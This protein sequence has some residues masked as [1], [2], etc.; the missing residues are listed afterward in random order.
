MAP[1]KLDIP[2]AIARAVM[3]D[4]R[5]YHA[6]TSGI[7]RDAIA[8]NTRHILLEHL[9]VGTKLRLV[10]IKELFEQMKDEA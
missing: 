4:L 10:E 7:R 9:P 1:R 2:P 3:D 8:A 5:A 6:E